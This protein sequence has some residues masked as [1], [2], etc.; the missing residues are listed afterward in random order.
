M[1]FLKKLKNED[2]AVAILVGIALVALVGIIA[3]VADTGSI[4]HTRRS[5]QSAADAAALAGVQ[6]LPGNPGYAVEI[7]TGYA[8]A[9]SATISSS[10]V[11]VSIE[12]TIVPNDTIVVNVSDSDKSTFFAGIF[13]INTVSVGATAKA[14]VGS[15]TEY[16]G[17]VPWYLVEGDWVPG[18]D[19]SLYENKT[20]SV[21]F[22][23]E[24]TGGSLYRDNIAYGY[25][26]IM[27]IGDMIECLNGFKTGP[28]KQGT[29]SRV[30][31]A[32][33]L[34]SF[35]EITELL[36]DGSYGLEINDTQLVVCP[37]VTQATADNEE[38]PIIGFAP[39]IITYYDG[40]EVVGKFLGEAM[41]IS[42]GEVV[43]YT[44]S[45]LKS[46]RLVH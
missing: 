31:P 42:S 16:K 26:G 39:I 41:M 27:K 22:N 13:G 19:Y 2:G 10:D 25:Q 40:K 9:Q 43:G 8:V 3:Y 37:V 38:G 20:G 23:G 15:P 12:S 46:S 18:A 33:E 34:D 32:N 21:S 30:G 4:Y 7:A 29:E 17:L 44:G 6:E 36:S 5:M 11:S 24:S 45:G 1:K 28:T 35:S 14:M